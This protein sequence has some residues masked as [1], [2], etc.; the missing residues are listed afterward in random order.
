MADSGQAHAQQREHS[1]R[2]RHATEPGCDRANPGCEEQLGTPSSVKVLYGN[3]WSILNKVDELRLL[4]CD[5]SPD[6]ICITETW[7]NLDH[8]DAFLTLPGYSIVGRRDREDT[9]GGIG[10]GLLI[11]VRDGLKCPENKLPIYNAFNQCCAISVPIRGSR[12]IELVL[13]YRP[14]NLYNTISNDVTLNNDKL[15]HVVENV[16][17]PCVLVGDFNYSDIC[18]ERMSAEN[19]NA[20]SKTFLECI[21]DN[22]FSQHVDEPTR[23]RSKTLP[24]L[25][26]SSQANLVKSVQTLSPLGASDH[27]ML[28]IDIAAKVEFSST[29]EQ[30]PDWAKADIPGLR[31]CLQEVDWEA[32]FENCTTDEMWTIFKN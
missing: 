30:V 31:N 7:C 3:A 17:K 23:M 4:S 19:K 15:C 22:F 32:A 26:L 9:T 6:I 12:S 1:G 14:H 27:A 25:V 18:W 11:Y 8:T 10:G 29:T 28:L 2:D 5:I 13:V 24:D 16:P 21:Q 20:G